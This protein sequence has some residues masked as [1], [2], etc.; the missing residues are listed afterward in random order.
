MIW[1]YRIDKVTAVCSSKWLE[2]ILSHNKRKLWLGYQCDLSQV[3]SWTNSYLLYTFAQRLRN[4]TFCKSSWRVLSL[5]VL[6]NHQEQIS[7]SIPSIHCRIRRRSDWL[8][9]SWTSIKSCKLHVTPHTQSCISIT[10]TR[11]VLINHASAYRQFKSLTRCMW[12]I[13]W[14]WVCPSRF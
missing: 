2:A 4:T 12:S 14:S 7:N 6:L 11:H 13:P 10:N 1:S 5:R 3:C 8:K 9:Q